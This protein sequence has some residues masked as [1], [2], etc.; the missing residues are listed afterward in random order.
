L[1]CRSNHSTVVISDSLYCW[2]GKQKNFPSVHDNEEKRRFTSSVDI[3][4][5]STFQWERKLTTGT[6][7]VGV[8]QYACTNTMNNILF[9]GGSCKAHDCYHND[10]FELDTLTNNWRE[11]VNISPDNGPMSKRGCG[12]IFYNIN[13]EENLLIIGG[14]GEIPVTT[15]TNSQYVPSS[16]NPNHY[17]TNEIHIMCM[18]SS[19]GIT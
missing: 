7:P 14:Y 18:S 1:T 10:L 9:F 4:H 8:L 19:P 15:P 13:G 2:G 5:L 16:K 3:F 17:H 6:P 12:M 11:I